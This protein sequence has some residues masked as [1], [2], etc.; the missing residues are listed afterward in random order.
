MPSTIFFQSAAGNDLATL[1]MTFQVNGVNTD[2]TAVTVIV[3]DPTGLSTTHSYLGAAP[4]DVTKVSAGVYSLLVPC[5]IVG[6]WGYEW[7]GTGTASETEAGTFTVNPGGAAT[8]QF[9]TS[10]EELKD[11]LGI[12]TT[13]SDLACQKAIQAA[14]RAIEGHCGRHF[15]QVQQT[16]T[17][18]PYDIWE[19][20]LDDVVSLTALNID[21]QGTGVFD[22]AW[23]QNVDYQLATGIWEFNQLASGELRPYTQ[24]RVINGAAGGKFFP[25]IWPFAPLNRVQ[26]IG[27]WGWPEVPFAVQQATL[28][29][30]AEFFKL[31]DAPF[32]IAGTSE[33]GYMRIPKQNPYITRLLTPYISSK[34]KVGV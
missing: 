30:A 28:Q 8:A 21:T 32:G 13:A 2:P 26:A 1:T 11:R 17:F 3:T 15:Y 19:Q 20:P 25:F 34:R 23:V 6:L 18:V 22:Q 10:V 4:A 9:Y 29:V 24:A 7:N 12:T 31:K 27:T 16:R 5:T 33:F 14:A